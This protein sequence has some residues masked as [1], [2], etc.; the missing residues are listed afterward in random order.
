MLFI[1]AFIITWIAKHDIEP[2][3]LVETYSFI[4]YALNKKEK[5]YTN[6]PLSKI[7]I[8]I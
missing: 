3:A 8:M 5:Q 2:G 7:F 1:V 6:T 4:V